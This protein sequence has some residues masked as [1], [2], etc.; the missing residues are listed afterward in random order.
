MV[1]GKEVKRVKG[2]G[3]EYLAAATGS[4]LEWMTEA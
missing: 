2:Y 3:S 4:G 1:K